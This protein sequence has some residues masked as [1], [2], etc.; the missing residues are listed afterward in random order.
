MPGVWDEENWFDLADYADLDMQGCI[1]AMEENGRS[2]SSSSS[3]GSH[4]ADVSEVDRMD[5]DALPL[6]V[7]Q[8]GEPA[9]PTSSECQRISSSPVFSTGETGEEISAPSP[10]KLYTIDEI[11]AE[12]YSP[13]ASGNS[14]S[15]PSPGNGVDETSTGRRPCGDD[16]T[17]QTIGGSSDQ[18]EKTS[19]SAHL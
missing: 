13:S 19:G 7:A 6:P 16:H 15:Q 11:I 4:V 18:A 1:R 5:E 3:A 17:Q 2:S 9:V 10:G 14:R 8:P 12:R